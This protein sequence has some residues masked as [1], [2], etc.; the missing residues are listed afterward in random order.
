MKEQSITRKNIIDTLMTT[1]K[2]L[3]YV[4][5]LWEAG[6]ASFN[7]IDEWSDLD[8]M[9][10]VEDERV[11]DTFE[12][13]EKAVLTL[14]ETG[15]KFRLPEPTWHGHSQIFY[16]LK[17][18]SPFLF[19]DIVVIKKSNEGK[20]LQFQIHGEPIVHFDKIGVVKNDPIDSKSFLNRIE[21]RLETLKTTFDLFQVLTSGTP[22]ACSGMKKY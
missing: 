16:R 5:A 8:L 18:A 1:L 17:K 3:D 9:V 4:N 19:L 10:D 20:F 2:P 21:K 6:A 7:R 15:V 22:Q 12:S 11:G 14:S 13:I